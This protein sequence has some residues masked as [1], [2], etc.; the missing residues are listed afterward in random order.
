MSPIPSPSPKPMNITTWEVDDS[1]VDENGNLDETAFNDQ[2]LN[3]FNEIICDE[4]TSKDVVV[5]SKD[6]IP[7]NKELNDNEYIKTSANTTINF[8]GGKINLILPDEGE[9]TVQVED[10]KN[11]NFSLNGEGNIKITVP[12]ENVETTKAV[13]N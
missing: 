6:P 10:T 5:T 4:E 9:V 8:N 12:E 3:K 11:A 7:F 1:V 2:L 13:S